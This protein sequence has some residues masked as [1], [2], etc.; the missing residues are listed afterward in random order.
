[1]SG[2]ISASTLI[3]AAATAAVGGLVSKVLAPKTPKATVPEVTPPP[4][5]AKAPDEVLRR[6]SAAAATGGG[7]AAGPSS[8]LLTGVGGIDPG[9]LNLGKSKL[10]GQ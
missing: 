8:T 1:M 4:Q 10:L 5:A 9:G 6:A 3:S 7:M 2:A